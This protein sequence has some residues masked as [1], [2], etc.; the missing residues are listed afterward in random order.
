MKQPYREKI[1]NISNSLSEIIGLL[2][3]IFLYFINFTISKKLYD[4]IDIFLVILVY[5]EIAVQLF[6]SIFI[7]TRTIY[8]FIKEK[9]R[10]N[11][12]AKSEVKLTS[13]AENIEIGS[14]R[15]INPLFNY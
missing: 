2:I 1:L 14:K 6:P 3:F 8:L 5:I 15:K 4:Q 10:N 9:L 11:N 7:F 12:Q 13:Q